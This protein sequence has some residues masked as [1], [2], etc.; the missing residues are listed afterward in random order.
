[1]PKSAEQIRQREQSRIRTIL[2]GF[3]AFDDIQ[4]W[5][6]EADHLP[7]FV[8]YMPIS[9]IPVDDII[10]VRDWLNQNK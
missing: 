2:Q 8:R 1:M 10:F 6:I 3:Y 4:I 5:M 9:T 7:T